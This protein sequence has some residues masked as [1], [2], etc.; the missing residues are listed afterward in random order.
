MRCSKGSET[1]GTTRTRVQTGGAKKHQAQVR[2]NT[3]AADPGI[4]SIFGSHF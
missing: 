4:R 3:R 2:E 1:F